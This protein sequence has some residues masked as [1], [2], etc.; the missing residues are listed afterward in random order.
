M[1]EMSS[2]HAEVRQL[3]VS[4]TALL[5]KACHAPPASSHSHSQRKVPL[6][7]QSGLLENRA[8]GTC[9]LGLKVCKA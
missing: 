3:L 9:L 6:C 4:L 5:R 8:V 1:K 2:R 7:F